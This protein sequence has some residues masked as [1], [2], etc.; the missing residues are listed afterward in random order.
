M[1]MHTQTQTGPRKR[2]RVG[3]GVKVVGVRDFEASQPTYKRPHLSDDAGSD[4]NA[5]LQSLIVFC[6]GRLDRESQRRTKGE[7]RD[8]EKQEDDNDEV[9]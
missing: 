8:K 9:S 4:N 1:Q 7:R 6:D 3:E 2:G 5:R